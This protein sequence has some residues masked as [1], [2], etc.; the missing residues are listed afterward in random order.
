MKFEPGVRVLVVGAGISGMA[1]ARI[2]RAH[3]AEVTLSDSNTE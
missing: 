3:G 2:L 1:V